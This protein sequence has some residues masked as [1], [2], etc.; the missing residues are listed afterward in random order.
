MYA[1]E[2]SQVARGLSY[3]WVFP[4]YENILWPIK[5]IELVFSV[6]S[7]GLGKKS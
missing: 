2:T 7:K 3:S 4:L 5:I 1:S 6:S